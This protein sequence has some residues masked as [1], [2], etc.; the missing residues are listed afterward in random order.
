MRITFEASFHKT[1]DGN[2]CV[3]FIDIPNMVTEGYDLDDAISMAADLL[4]LW[5]TSEKLDGKTL[6]TP[7][8]GNKSDD[9]IIIAIS[10]CPGSPET[11]IE[12]TNTREAAEMLKVSPSR[13]RKMIKAGQIR[14]KKD[15]RDLMVS[16]PDVFALALQP[17][18]AGRPRKVK[19]TEFVPAT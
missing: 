3:Q 2:Y 15:G 6:P 16:F 17:R 13:I 1:V 12:W 10:V 18:P 11:V 9:D 7:T 19:E 5:Y 14:S 8:Y 4:E